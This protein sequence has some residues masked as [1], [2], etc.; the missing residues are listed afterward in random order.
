MG[1]FSEPDGERALREL[2]VDA[3]DALTKMRG[4]L[5]KSGG[6]QDELHSYIRR[7]ERIA[8]YITHALQN[9][10]DEPDQRKDALIE[11]LQT[12]RYLLR[13]VRIR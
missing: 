1:L 12:A 7:C 3:Q 5:L 13:M 10:P 9:L 11:H 2:K 8:T 4:A 6:T